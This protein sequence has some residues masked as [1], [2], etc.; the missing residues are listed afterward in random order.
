MIKRIQTHIDM[1]KGRIEI[2][3]EIP[4]DKIRRQELMGG[5]I[6]LYSFC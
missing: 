3:T 5:K 1:K 2:H 6:A 4:G